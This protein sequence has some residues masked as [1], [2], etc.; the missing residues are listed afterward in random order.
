M[1]TEFAY[2]TY[3]LSKFFHC[4]S[5]LRVERARANRLTELPSAMMIT[6]PY[7]GVVPRQQSCN[8]PHRLQ[9]GVAAVGSSGSGLLLRAVGFSH[10]GV[11]FSCAPQLV[12]LLDSCNNNAAVV[13]LAG[14][15]ACVRFSR[16]QSPSMG[17]SERRHSMPMLNNGKPAANA[18]W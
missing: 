14:A 7:L 11:G 9:R 1:S 16:R 3:T 4:A 12:S 17:I 10:K 18:W 6:Y 13:S 2:H 15:L 5:P 8:N